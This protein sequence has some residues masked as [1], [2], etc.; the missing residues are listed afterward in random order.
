M[1]GA[2]LFE[3]EL[4]KG[5]TLP[6]KQAN[7]RRTAAKKALRIAERA[8]AAVVPN[9]NARN[10]IHRLRT[11]GNIASLQVDLRRA[12]RERDELQAALDRERADAAQ[13]RFASDKVVSELRGRLASVR[14]ELSCYE[15]AARQRNQRVPEDDHKQH[16]EHARLADAAQREHVRLVDNLQRQH[17]Q[18]VNDLKQSFEERLRTLQTERDELAET[19]AR[20]RRER[21]ESRQSYLRYRS[22]VVNDTERRR[23]RLDAAVRLRSIISGSPPAETPDHCSPTFSDLE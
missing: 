10:E 7:R 15:R 8:A 17:E 13:E 23:Q 4:A 21:N 11:E 19:V 12:R 18:H 5:P 3:A 2:E 20:V 9:I 6:F 1:S 14:Q 22:I 16:Q